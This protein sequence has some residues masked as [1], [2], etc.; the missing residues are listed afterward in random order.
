[1]SIVGQRVLEILREQRD[2]PSLAQELVITNYLERKELWS[3][4]VEEYANYHSGIHSATTSFIRNYW[5]DDSITKDL[6]F[7]VAT[8][9]VKIV[10]DEEKRRLKLWWN[11]QFNRVG[12]WMSRTEKVHKE[13][14]KLSDI[15]H[16]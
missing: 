5:H 6:R 8:S 16:H 3:L 11:R 14:E 4:S 1:M 12:K 7:R 10:D 2:P 13:K 15:Q 9:L